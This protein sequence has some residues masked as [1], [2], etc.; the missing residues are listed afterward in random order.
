MSF[1]I[2]NGTEAISFLTKSKRQNLPSPIA[3]LTPVVDFS[4]HLSFYLSKQVLKKKALLLHA[5]KSKNVCFLLTKRLL[6]AHTSNQRSS[7]N[8]S[9]S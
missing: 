6:C 2:R 4:L 5:N 9:P 3:H 8:L 1:V 7:L